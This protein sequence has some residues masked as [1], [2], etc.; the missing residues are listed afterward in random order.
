MK[1]QYRETLL[2]QNAIFRLWFLI[3]KTSLNN[4]NVNYFDVKRIETNAYISQINDKIPI[5][6]SNCKR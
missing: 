2:F 5:K 1:N 3:T 6:I 4:V